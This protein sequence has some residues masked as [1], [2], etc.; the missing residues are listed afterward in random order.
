M[1]PDGALGGSDRRAVPDFEGDARAILAGPRSD[2]TF[3][4]CSVCGD[5]ADADGDLDIIILC[6]YE[7]CLS[8]VDALGRAGPACVHI[9]CMRPVQRAV[10]K[11]AWFCSAACRARHNK[12]R[13]QRR[14]APAEA[15]ARRP[16]VRPVPDRP[17]PRLTLPAAPSRGTQSV[18][19]ALQ[20]TA[21]RTANARDEG[22]KLPAGALAGPQKRKG[23]LVAS[24]ILAKMRK[25]EPQQHPQPTRDIRLAQPQTQGSTWEG[26]VVVELNGERLSMRV[27]ANGILGRV[28]QSEHA[29]AALEPLRELTATLVKDAHAHEYREDAEA[30]AALF[31]GVREDAGSRAASRQLLSHLALH[32]NQALVA[33]LRGGGHVVLVP[34]NGLKTFRALFLRPRPAPLHKKFRRGDLE[35]TKRFKPLLKKPGA[36]PRQLQVVW[37]PAVVNRERGDALYGEVGRINPGK[38][39]AKPQRTTLE[40]RRSIVPTVEAEPPRPSG[41]PAEGAELPRRSVV[42][43]VEVKLPPAGPAPPPP[44]ATAQGRT[45]EVAG[46]S[47]AGVAD[48]ARQEQAEPARSAATS[49]NVAEWRPASPVPLH[50][51]RCLCLWSQDPAQHARES[52]QQQELQAAL[53]RLAA[54]G[55]QEVPGGR[56]DCAA[57]EVGVLLV[58]LG[59]EWVQRGLE[60]CAGLRRVHKLGLRALLACPHAIFMTVPGALGLLH[61][62][63][64][65]QSWVDPMS[66]YR[67]GYDGG[68]LL[69][70]G[71]AVVSD[72]ATITGKRWLREVPAIV[73][74]I[75]LCG[76]SCP[77][78]SP[79]LPVLEKAQLNVVRNVLPREWPPEVAQIFK[80]A[81]SA[82]PDEFVMGLEPAA[83][84]AHG[85]NSSI[86]AAALQLARC[87]ARG[88]RFVIVMTADPKAVEEAA[89][90]QSVFAAAPP[91]VA[92]MLADIHACSSCWSEPA[93]AA[94]LQHSGPLA[95]LLA[96]GPGSEPS[97][98]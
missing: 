95:S 96:G 84:G 59:Q 30:H 70:A 97:G 1:P 57:P 61:A 65:E 60:G 3:E 34:G 98:S 62:C 92:A 71:V 41:V 82:Q 56:F 19:P 29:V 8:G 83:S 32:H 12:G 51:V 46:T 76:E 90:L 44:A 13:V 54:N 77:R 72:T 5:W 4:L 58:V 52:A 91:Q 39:K 27:T 10:P 73:E 36:A 45:A 49:A 80:Q 42:P 89:G 18:S 86:V 15:T 66:L 85:G 74:Q 88:Y 69:P 21:S 6:E 81:V 33:G 79:W 31:V 24:D 93:E 48:A 53:R 28:E 87:S 64:R 68:L 11:E 63:A 78:R 9:H 40:L 14:E 35:T 22:A 2:A 7:N 38:A 43:T 75:H 20:P 55:V 50:A 16:R 67:N 23:T 37:D 26:C 47:G 94:A 25:Q 17:A